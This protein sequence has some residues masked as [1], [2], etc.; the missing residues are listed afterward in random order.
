MK[1][2]FAV[3]FMPGRVVL[4]GFETSCSVIGT[5]VQADVSLCCTPDFEMHCFGQN[6]EG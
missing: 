4:V 6:V 1:K 5:A 2:T 3:I